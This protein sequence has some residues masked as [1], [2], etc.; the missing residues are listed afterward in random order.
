M[1]FVIT[2]THAQP[3]DLAKRGSSAQI[4]A[5]LYAHNVIRGT[6]NATS[7][8]W[9][10]EYAARAEVWADAC[11]FTLTGGNLSATPYGE[12]HTAATGNFNIP[13]AIGEFVKD[14]GVFVAYINI[15]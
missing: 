15:N 14:K 1:T 12:L 7:L 11:E 13:T 3:H 6:H 4:D 10:P 2:V 9:S 8:T 5:F